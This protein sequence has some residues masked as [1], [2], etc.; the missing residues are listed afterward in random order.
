[1]N[2]KAG[3]TLKN[4]AILNVVLAGFGAILGSIDRNLPYVL[5]EISAALGWFV[6]SRLVND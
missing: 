6:V 2:I 5:A 1:M 4:I 3:R